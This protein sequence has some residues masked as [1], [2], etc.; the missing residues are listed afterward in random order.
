MKKKKNGGHLSVGELRR[1]GA[2]LKGITNI[3]ENQW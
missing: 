1:D 3:F 2:G